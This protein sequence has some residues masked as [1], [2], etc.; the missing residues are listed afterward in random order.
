MEFIEEWEE[1][2]GCNLGEEDGQ[3]VVDCPSNDP[4]LH[5][6][7][8][9]GAV[10]KFNENDCD[11]ESHEPALGFVPQP[12]LELLVRQVELM[13]DA[14]TVVVEREAEGLADDEQHQHVKE[15]RNCVTLS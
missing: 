7:D 3:S 10:D 2:D 6:R 1:D 11:D 9:N 14:I 5:G 4:P 12:G 13:L 15:H 8:T